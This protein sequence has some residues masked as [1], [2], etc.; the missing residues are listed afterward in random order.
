MLVYK[1]EN[2]KLDGLLIRIRIRLRVSLTLCLGFLRRVADI[3]ARTPKR[4]VSY[5]CVFSM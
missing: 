3:F 5:R 1:E 2:K 4:Y